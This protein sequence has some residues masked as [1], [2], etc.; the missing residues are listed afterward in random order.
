[1]QPASTMMTTPASGPS[2]KLAQI[3]STLSLNAAQAATMKANP[4]VILT[5]DKDIKENCRE[6]KL[7]VNLEEEVEAIHTNN[8]DYA[9]RVV[10]LEDDLKTGNKTIQILQGLMTTAPTLQAI[11]LPH[12]PEY[13]GDRKELLR[14]I[15]KVHSKLAGENGHF[16]NDQYKSHYI[17]GYL[18]GNAQNQIQLYVQTDKMSLDKVEALIKILEAAFGNPDKVGMAS[19]ELDCLMQG[20]C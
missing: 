13:S 20:N 12:P 10:S 1:M 16:S 4:L 18:K 15:S 11:E 9:Q 19:G 5:I 3:T 14:F 2:D 17:Y 6:L 7:I 8:T